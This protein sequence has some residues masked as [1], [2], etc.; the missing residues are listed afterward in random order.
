MAKAQG[1]CEVCGKLLQWDSSQPF[2][3]A[4]AKHPICPKTCFKQRQAEEDARVAKKAA[5]ASAMYG[6]PPTMTTKQMARW[7]KAG[8]EERLRMME[9]GEREMDQEL[10]RGYNPPYPCSYVGRNG[11]CKQPAKVASHFCQRHRALNKT[12]RDCLIRY[13]APTPAPDAP[14]PTVKCSRCGRVEVGSTHGGAPAVCSCGGEMQQ[15]IA[16]GYNPCVR[17]N[18]QDEDMRAIARTLS[19]DEV[20]LL[21]ATRFWSMGSA[22]PT[23]WRGVLSVLHK[24]GIKSP[25]AEK[26]AA[27][28]KARGWVVVSGKRTGK[29]IGLTNTGHRASEVISRGVELLPWDWRSTFPDVEFLL[30]KPNPPL[31]IVGAGILANP[32]EG[33]TCWYCSLPLS[34]GQDLC[35]RCGSTNSEMYNPPSGNLGQCFGLGCKEPARKHVHV[36]AYGGMIPLCYRCASMV[37]PSGASD[38]DRQTW[39][40]KTNP[41]VPCGENPLTPGETADGIKT[42]EHI[43]ARALNFKNNLTLEQRRDLMWRAAGQG[44]ILD[45]YSD[46][47][48]G[49][50]EADEENVK[51]VARAARLGSQA[52][53]YSRGHDRAG[54]KANPTDRKRKGDKGKKVEISIEAARA[55]ATK[56]GQADAFEAAMKAHK[57]FHGIYPDKVTVYRFPDGKKKINRK[58]VA[59]L[60]RVPE[61]HYYKAHPKGNKAKTYWVHKHPPGGEPL[62]VLDPST[63]LTSKIGGTCKVTTWWYH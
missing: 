58:F 7:V 43:Q 35:P 40:M 16:R 6:L 14:A 44:D 46:W 3:D 50:G 39:G 47:G 4:F 34:S 33:L 13:P 36:P 20:L 51:N 59:G 15:E 53:A 12:P 62:E 26:A 28:L 37:P 31:A 32:H 25:A 2:A 45:I 57:T 48:G 1:N 29:T 5:H 27:S 9:E 22:T 11:P 19:R 30:T 10:A 60:G 23:L 52:A 55:F 17:E 41:C 61:T 38:H 49:K 8:P 54:S 21:S 56:I 42:A 63:G 24:Q 18:P